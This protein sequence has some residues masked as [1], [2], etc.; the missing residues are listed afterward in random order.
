ML[1]NTGMISINLF[2]ANFINAFA[3]SLLLKCFAR[4]SHITTQWNMCLISNLMH[5]TRKCSGIAVSLHIIA[6]YPALLI[7]RSLEWATT[8]ICS[9]GDDRTWIF[10]WWQSFTYCEQ[11]GGPMAILA[12]QKALL[13]DSSSYI[14]RITNCCKCFL[15]QPWCLFGRQLWHV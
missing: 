4:C 1:G 14:A 15:R 13:I 12:F 9:F 3:R 8:L 6:G 5:V 7:K 11:I 2:H 10:M